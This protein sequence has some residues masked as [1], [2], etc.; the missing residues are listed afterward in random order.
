MSAYSMQIF[1]NLAISH[2]KMFA[3]A[4]AKAQ[5]VYFLSL[6]LFGWVGQF[7]LVGWGKH[8]HFLSLC[9]LANSLPVYFPRVARRGRT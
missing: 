9:K 8:T 3:D 7:A 5:I 4:V 2:K 1:I 6:S